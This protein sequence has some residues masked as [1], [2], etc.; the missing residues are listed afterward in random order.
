MWNKLL[1]YTSKTTQPDD[2]RKNAYFPLI[3]SIVP[4][5]TTYTTSRDLCNWPWLH[6]KKEDSA[7]L[8]HKKSRHRWS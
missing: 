5:R 3:T 8:M 7:G 4:V 1:F 2:M 6:R